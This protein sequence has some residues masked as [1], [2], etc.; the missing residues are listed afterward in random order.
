MQKLLALSL[1][2]A[3]QLGLP[4][5]AKDLAAKA[6]RDE[7]VFMPDDDPAMRRAFQQARAT[8][9][10]FL[11]KAAKPPKGTDHYAVKVGIRD[12][13]QTEYFWISDFSA[14]SGKFSGQISNE[15]QLVSNVEAGETYQ[16][17]KGEIV[18]WLYVDNNS[19]RM[20]GN[21]TAC[22]LLS[23]EPPAV[24]ADMKK[25]FGLHCS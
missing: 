9:D 8:L 18:D 6:E 7:V 10:D 25:R 13:K 12:G 24:A 1:L 15:P 22:A 23:K 21:F 11:A 14:K 16:F 2:L 4:A 3:C 5:H 20:M 19:G 17:G